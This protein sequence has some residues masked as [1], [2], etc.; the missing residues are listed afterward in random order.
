MPGGPT[1]CPCGWWSGWRS[2]RGART[3]SILLLGRA[4][5]SLAQQLRFLERHLETDLRGNHLIKNIRALLWA[6]A[7]FA[8]PE[9]E[10]WSA[11]GRRLLRREL[12]EQ[13]LPDGCH[14]ER[15]PAYQCQVL[16]DLLACRAALPNTL[17]ELDAAL[18][19]MVHALCLL[20]HPDGRVAQFNDGGLSMALLPG[21]L[22]E[23][24]TRLI[25]SPPAPAIGRVRAA[26]RGLFRPQGRGRAAGR[27][28]R[29][30]GAVPTCRGTATAILLAFEW[31][32][33]GRRIV[34]DQ[35]THQYLADP[36]RLASRSTPATT[37]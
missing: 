33:G 23:A 18:A 25:G 19:R 11:L 29:R 1:T 22:L 5:A 7:F 28:L 26:G 34:V 2:W 27:R 14:Y 37:R 30:A 21:H 13:V 12:A 6:G 3:G 35:G 10:R 20:T 9:A 8:G 16:E 36:R 32:T 17:P 4:Q 24:W 31:S 15:S